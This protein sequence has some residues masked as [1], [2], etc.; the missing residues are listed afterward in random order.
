MI[1]YD[2]HLQAIEADGHV[3]EYKPEKIPKKLPDI[4]FIEGPNDCGKST[5]LNAIAIGLWGQENKTIHDS[6]HIKMK[7]LMDP[8]FNKLTFNISLK[9]KN[10]TLQIISNKSNPDEP[11]FDI[12]EIENGV[13]NRL[14]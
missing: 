13:K 11:K 6:L 14:I 4:V 8:N 1:E 10:S 3:S 9:N 7:D 2:Y 12:F 5:I